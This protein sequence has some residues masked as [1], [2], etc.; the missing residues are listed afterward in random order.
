MPES[1]F[2]IDFY[3]DY[4]DENYVNIFLEAI[5]SVKRRLEMGV[6]HAESRPTPFYFTRCSNCGFYILTNRDE[7]YDINCQNCSYH[8]KTCAIN[9]PELNTL[10]DEIHKALGKS[11]VNLKGYML[12]L[13]IQPNDPEQIDNIYKLCKNAGFEKSD[14]ADT[15]CF[16]AYTEGFQRQI[17]TPDRQI[18][19][20]K[21]VCNEDVLAYSNE[22]AP[23]IYKLVREIR[24]I[25]PGMNSFSADFDPDPQYKDLDYLFM[26]GKFDEVED[27]V[28]KK[29]QVDPSN[30]ENLIRLSILLQ[31]KGELNEAEDKILFAKTID[32]INSD[33]LSQLGSVQLGLGNYEAAIKALEQAVEENPLDGMALYKMILCY[34]KIGR[35]DLA[36]K[37]Q[38]RLQSI[39]G[40]L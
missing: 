5:T 21:M 2:S 23:F 19:F 20:F 39:G 17:F 27:A 15:F 13:L 8:D 34:Q 4:M 37:T 10:L 14:D 6:G 38:A 28:R 36:S 33:V 9:A 25:D 7:G 31:N 1:T 40:V 30:V 18:L 35:L 12:I 24:R 29:L 16:M 3:E 32:P 22:T 11:L 26:Q